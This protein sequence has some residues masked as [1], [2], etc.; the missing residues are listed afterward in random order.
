MRK[1]EEYIQG[2]LE[3]SAT[4]QVLGINIKIIG[5]SSDIAFSSSGSR[6]RPGQK[7][8]GKTAVLLHYDTSDPQQAHYV[9]GVKK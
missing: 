4:C 8:T 2:E 1:P 9:L 5:K 3:I 6:Q 7:M